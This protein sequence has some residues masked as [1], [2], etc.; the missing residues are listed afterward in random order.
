[1]FLREERDLLLCKILT[2]FNI[3]YD[4][5]NNIYSF[6]YIPLEIYKEK[7]HFRRLFIYNSINLSMSR[8]N[9]FNHQEIENT[10]DEHWAFR[11]LLT[12]FGIDIYDNPS[13]QAIN[14]ATCGN[15]VLPYTSL[16]KIPYDQIPKR[17][18]CHCI[19][20]VE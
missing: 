3:P 8:A 10:E 1:M 9:G 13:L 17:I 19:Y 12:I 4:I 18:C 6:L 14:C 5:I 15:Y 20:I 2:K 16:H 11:P 7:L